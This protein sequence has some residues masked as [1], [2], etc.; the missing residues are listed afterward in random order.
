MDLIKHFTVIDFASR[1]LKFRVS[2][3]VAKSITCGIRHFIDIGK[4]L[5]KIDVLDGTL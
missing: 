1:A 3:R 5:S 4:L 2:F